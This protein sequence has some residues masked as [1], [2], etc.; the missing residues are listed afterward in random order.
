MSNNSRTISKGINEKN[1]NDYINLLT[2][3]NI[4][5]N[6]K[7]NKL[8]SIETTKDSRYQKNDFK[9]FQRNNKFLDEQRKKKCIKKV[10]LHYQKS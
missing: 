3:N 8:K 7:N 6:E 1:K 4:K 9:N 5:N 10:D 2:I